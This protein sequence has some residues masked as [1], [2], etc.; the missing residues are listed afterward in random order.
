MTYQ[1]QRRV[2][3]V[4]LGPVEA[5]RRSSQEMKEVEYEVEDLVENFIA[6]TKGPSPSIY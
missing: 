1:S 2:S 4:G 6:L 3:T 5:L